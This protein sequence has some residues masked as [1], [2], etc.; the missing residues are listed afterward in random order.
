[1]YSVSGYRTGVVGWLGQEEGG[2]TSSKANIK[3]RRSDMM[4]L[5]SLNECV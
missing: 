2:G 5:M 3:I 1:M 4:K